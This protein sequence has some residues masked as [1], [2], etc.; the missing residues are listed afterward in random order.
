MYS[1]KATSEVGLEFFSS[2]KEYRATLARIY[3]TSGKF[4]MLQ[5]NP[6]SNDSN[7]HYKFPYHIHIACIWVAVDI[8]LVGVL[9]IPVE[10][11]WCPYLNVVP[12]LSHDSFIIE[13]GKCISSL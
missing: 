7:R 2:L 3:R 10:V 8:L 9:S 1:N 4:Y 13:R 6:N 5:C 11:L 12:H